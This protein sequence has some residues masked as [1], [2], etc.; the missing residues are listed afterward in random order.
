MIARVV[1]PYP[2]DV[3]QSY[4]EDGHADRVSRRDRPTS[5]WFRGLSGTCSTWRIF[6]PAGRLTWREWYWL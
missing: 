1:S 5:F 6:L 3:S 2:A 4:D